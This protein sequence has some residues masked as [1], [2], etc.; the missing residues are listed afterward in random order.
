MQSST[1]KNETHDYVIIDYGM[2][3]RVPQKTATRRM[4][5]IPWKGGGKIKYTAPEVAIRN[6]DCRYFDPESADIWSAGIV[7]FM[8][9]SGGF[10]L[11]ESP[12]HSC[13][14]CNQLC[15]GSLKEICSSYGLDL[16]E[17]VMN[18]LQQIYHKDPACRTSIAH[19]LEHPRFDV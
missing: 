13:V 15:A 16:T 14:R 7:L 12:T 8:M 1:E 6:R 17:N 9:L 18:L 4:L 2:C 3:I 11:V 19:I 5:N 10:P